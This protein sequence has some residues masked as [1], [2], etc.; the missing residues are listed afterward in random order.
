VLDGD[1]DRFIKAYL[2]AKAAGRLAASGADAE[3]G[4]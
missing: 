1:L 2:M 3:A 4:D